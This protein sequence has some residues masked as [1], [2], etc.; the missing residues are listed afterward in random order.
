MFVI[1]IP[2]QRAADNFIHTSRVFR[3]LCLSGSIASSEER[4]LSTISGKTKNDV[5]YMCERDM[6]CG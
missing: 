6:F 4:V 2:Y 1:D 3:N 5:I